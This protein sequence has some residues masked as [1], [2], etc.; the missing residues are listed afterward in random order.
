MS[1]PSNP[2][3][4]HY[5]PA[6]GAASLRIIDGP[7]AWLGDDLRDSDVWI[8]PFSEAEI[9]ELEAALAH[10]KTLRLPLAEVRKEHFP[11]P[12]L[13]PVLAH[14]QD[15]VLNG[16]GFQLMRGLPVQRYS[17]EESATIYWGMGMH[18]G[19][20]VPQNAQGHLLGHVRSLDYDLNDPNVRVY[21]TRERQ[22]FHTDSC[23]IVALLCLQT[24]KS[25]GLS[26]L[27]SSV[28]IYNEMVRRR[29][30]LA[31]L[32]FEPFATDRRGEVPEGMMPYFN[33]PVF[34]EYEGHF[35]VI[36]ARRYIMSA[37][38]FPEVPRLTEAQLEALD[39]VDSL[40][41][42]PHFRIDMELR[43]G[44]IQYV[45]NHVVLHDR[46]EYEDWPEPE[47]KRHLL[48]FW[49]CPPNGRPLPPAY[50]QRYGSVEIGN[51]GGIR[52]PGQQL[53]APLEP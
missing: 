1:H 10:V 41:E 24:A 35:S 25:G 52:V 42:D 46:T 38:R 33:L 5:D 39:L 34:N 27:S 53:V 6:V 19:R 22:T 18:L 9:A 21:Q 50:A 15:E 11:L 31:A 49:L 43:P 48:R 30:D 32:L 44:D 37:Q 45:C 20:P 17:I 51:R 13:G 16:R 8:H 12:T 40:A 28:S 4:S 47:R 26:S 14:I 23:D 36:Y 7:A 29:P 2:T 3:S